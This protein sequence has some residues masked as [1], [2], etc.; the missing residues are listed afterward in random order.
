MKPLLLAPVHQS[1]E[2]FPGDILV[3]AREPTPARPVVR[4]AQ[5]KAQ[6]EARISCTL[7]EVFVCVRPG[8]R[9]WFDD[10]KI[11]GEVIEVGPDA[12][13]V[14]IGPSAAEVKTL[15]ED[16]GINLPDSRIDVS[17][18]TEKD[19]ADLDF[20]ARHAD[21]VGLSFIQ[22]PEDVE[23]LESELCN[24]TE[25]P[26]GMVLKIETRRA[27]DSLPQILLA[28]LRSRPIGVMIARGDLAVEC[29]YERL[30]EVQE[31]ILWLCEAAHMPSVWATQVLERLS[32]K[33]QPSRAE[34]T[35]A[36]MGR[37]A[38]CVMLNKGPH[39]VEAVRMLVDILARMGGHQEKKSALLRP[40]GVSR[41]RTD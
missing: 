38:E 12:L 40:L 19:R 25:R 35:D 28:A 26:V 6:G 3:L 10:G 36:A 30:A 23:Q 7:P 33:G 17:A 9:I 22:R 13:R 27:F 4:D 29:G 32:K 39:I 34:I 31:E 20:V 8:E 21:L 41:R 15:R 16:K 14:R 1:I 2:L 11:G 37:R 5:G 18:I 24:R